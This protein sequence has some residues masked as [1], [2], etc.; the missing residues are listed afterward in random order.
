MA[1]I[2]GIFAVSHTPVMTNLP[3]APPPA[4]REEI[5]A[6]FRQIG[7]TIADQRPDAIIVISDDHLHNFFLDNMPAFC[8]GAGESHDSPME[9]WLKVERRELRGHRDLAAHLIDRSF[10]SGFDP[11]F[12]L[13]LTLDHG[14]VTPLEL[15]GITTLAPIVPVI[16]NTV[17]PPMPRMAR[18][19]AFGQALG[20]AL[21]DYPGC[22]RIV[23]LATGGLSH[24]VGTPRMGMVNETFDRGFLDRLETGDDAELV[25]FAEAEVGQAGNGA[26]EVRNWL[27]AHGIADGARFQSI[28]YR[29]V[30]SWYTGI[31]LGRWVQA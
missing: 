8:I 11:S 29:A 14:I 27:V 15:A 24:D 9:A 21:R 3:D 26:E 4:E 6:H 17:Q 20:A 5:F 23:V 19:I 18:C 13:S 2:I 22:Q 30:P 25:A 10:A 12:S 1:D 16:V 7:R 31:A 28:H